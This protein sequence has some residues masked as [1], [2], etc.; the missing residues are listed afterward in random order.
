MTGWSRM[1]LKP[2]RTAEYPEGKPRREQLLL[3]PQRFD[4]LPP[5]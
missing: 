4:R 2:T 5:C 3:A 1:R